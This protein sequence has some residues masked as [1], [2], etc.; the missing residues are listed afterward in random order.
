MVPAAIS[1]T[2][3]KR[4]IPLSDNAISWMQWYF[5]ATQ[6]QPNGDERLM[7]QWSLMK[8]RASRRANYEAAAGEGAKWPQNCKR[9]AFASHFIAAHRNMTYSGLAMGHKSTEITF[10]HYVG[11][12]TH[13][14]GLAS[15]SAQACGKH[16]LAGCKRAFSTTW[17]QNSMTS[18][19]MPHSGLLQ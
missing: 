15:K 12:V 2:K 17:N 11:A 14:A 8:L 7:S 9:H 13:E 19:V 16:Q 18:P 5:Q 10:D 6:R 1:K 4:I 3:Q